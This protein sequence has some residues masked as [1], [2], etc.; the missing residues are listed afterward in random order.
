MPRWRCRR[1]NHL[2]QRRTVIERHDAHAKATQ[3]LLRDR[4][5]RCRHAQATTTPTDGGAAAEPAA[6]VA[7]TV[8]VA[9]LPD[10]AGL[11]S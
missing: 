3:R 9:T 7:V 2:G 11:H 5:D 4:A 6:L 1:R 8:Q 10:I